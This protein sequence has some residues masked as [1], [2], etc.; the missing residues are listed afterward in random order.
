VEVNS[1]K[2]S[3]KRLWKNQSQD[4]RQMSTHVREIS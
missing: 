1:D 2:V 3:E 4:V